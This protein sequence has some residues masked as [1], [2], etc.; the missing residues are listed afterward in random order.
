MNIY[1]RLLCTSFEKEQKLSM[2]KSGEAT[3][4][5]QTRK[6]CYANLW[7]KLVVYEN[8]QRKRTWKESNESTSW[9]SN[10]K[11]WIVSKEDSLVHLVEW[12]GYIIFWAI[13]KGLNA[14]KSCQQLDNLRA[15]IQ[16]KIWLIGKKF[17]FT[18]TKPHTSN[19]TQKKLFVLG[20]EFPPHPAY[21]AIR[22]S[23]FAKQFGRKK[24]KSEEAVRKHLDFILWINRFMIEAF[25]WYLNIGKRS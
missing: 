6:R 8:L 17:S 16:E 14:D 13:A 24:F 4:S 3:G 12:Q 9:S 2:S 11:T 23:F 19:I 25:K 22:L 10:S 5:I 21:C 1:V 15:A 18:M 7:Q 20:W